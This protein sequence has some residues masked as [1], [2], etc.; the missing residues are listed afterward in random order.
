MFVLTIRKFVIDPGKLAVL[1]VKYPRR[2]E[3]KIVSTRVKYE[4][5]KLCRYLLGFRRIS[6]DIE[7][8][9]EHIVVSQW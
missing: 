1:S 8:T 3:V 9:E 2:G 4:P 7:S 6:I 5:D